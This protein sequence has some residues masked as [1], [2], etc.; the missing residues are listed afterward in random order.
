MSTAPLNTAPPVETRTN[1]HLSGVFAPV[2]DEVDVPDLHVEGQ[3]P[4]EIDGDYVRNGPNPRFTPLGAYVYPL[5]G[6][7][8]LHRVQIRGGSVR[9]TNRFVQ[10][11]AL[12]AEEAAGRALWPGITGFGQGPGA[13]VV[14]PELAH[15]SKDLPDI[16]VVRHGGRLLALAESANPFL[17]SAELQTLGR[18][19]FCG[20]LP[21]GITAHPKIDP[22][23]GEMV[24]FCYGLEEPYL[25]WSV[26]GPDG[27]ATRAAT[28]VEEVDRP[29]MIHDMALTERFVVLVLAPFFF[30]IPGALQGGSP[31]SWEPD[32]GTRIALIPRD[33]GPVRWFHEEAFWMWHTANAHERDG[34]VVLD[35]VQWT[36]PGGLVQGAST[37][38]L[39]RLALDPTTGRATRTVLA[40]RN[41]EF[42]RIDDRALTANHEVVAVSLRTAPGSVNDPDTLGWFDTRTGELAV[43]ESSGL[44]LGEQVFVPR[45]EDPDPGHGWWVTYA[46]DRADLTSSLL[47]LP[48]ADP[49]AGPVARVHLPQRVPLGLHGSWLPGR[50]SA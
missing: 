19:T 42:P 18:E 24:A 37:G 47:V 38:S 7:G 17:I 20:T 22:R 11:P 32:R 34:R 13:D 27:V 14:G 41:M 49:T 30:D 31:L 44:A 15:T 26:L 5:D 43:W 36:L 12:V 39:S 2:V 29:V 23:T 8:M 3:L 1:P 45:P 10:T 35:Y 40:D 33:G 48:A 9:Y 46:T 4:E 50:S 25:T 6:D 28:P 21:A 16:N